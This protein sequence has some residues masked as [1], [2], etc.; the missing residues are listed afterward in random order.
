MI[1]PDGY[2]LILGCSID[3]QFGPVLLFGAGGQLVEVFKDRALALPPLDRALARRLI[4][5]TSIYTALKGVR[6]R[7]PVDLEALEDLL[8][9][10]SAL[11]VGQP[12]IREVDINPLAASPRGLLALDARIVVQEQ[13][14]ANAGLVPFK[15]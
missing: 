7:A 4:E 8:L 5:Q 2:E 15:Q 14:P 11:V 6:G 12:W 10:F 3:P 13:A 9:R 1:P